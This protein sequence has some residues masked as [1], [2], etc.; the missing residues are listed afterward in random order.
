MTRPSWW[1]VL[2]VV[3]IPMLSGC[4][5]ERKIDPVEGQVGES[6]MIV[7]NAY[8]Q[9]T[10]KNKRPPKGPEEL[11]PFLPAD[12]PADSLLRSVRDG[13]PFVILWGTDPREGM[14]VKPLV[15]GYEQKGKDGTRMVFTAMGVMT[16]DEAGF[17][18]A[19]FPP[20]HKP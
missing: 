6:L 15:I 17:A 8:L 16:M 7:A 1:F 11:K 10:E 14:D 18:A 20:G 13:E 5:R 3:A 19:R 9:A 4:A 12:K 2:L